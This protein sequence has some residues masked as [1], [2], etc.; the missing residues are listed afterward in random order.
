MAF[1]RAGSERINAF[2]VGETYLF[3]HYFDDEEVFGEL[4]RYY[5]EYEYRFEVPDS[6]LE[7]VSDFLDRHGYAL[8]AVDEVEEFAVV[9]RKYTDHPRVLFKGSVFHRSQG[10]FNCFVMKDRDAFQQ[11]LGAGATPL[12]ETDLD[13][14]LSDQSRSQ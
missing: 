14:V 11:A 5:D 1:H 12:L 3:K 9:K 13:L 8:V 10:N 4:Q 7:H 2:P 6:R